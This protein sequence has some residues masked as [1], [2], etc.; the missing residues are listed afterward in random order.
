M[1]LKK[2]LLL[3]SSGIDSVIAGYIVLSSNIEIVAVHFI[4]YPYS[5]GTLE[6]AKMLVKKLEKITKKDIKLYSVPI[7]EHLKNFKNRANEKLTCI[8]CKRLMFRIG[9]KIAKK[10]GCN[11]LL[12]GEN[13]GQVASQT[14]ENMATIESCIKI[15][16]IRPLLCFD[17]E[18]TIKIAKKIGTYDISIQ[19]EIGCKAVPKYPR[20]KT[21]LHEIE[22]EEK[23]FN[24]GKMIKESLK[25]VILVL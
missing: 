19:K 10:E 8:F 15:P 12:T 25:R 16:V 2:G 4:N 18:E 21:T 9:E 11:F 23:K 5:S 22:R 17:K 13:L 7:G 24:I 3:L 6:K 20:T 1:E 14:L